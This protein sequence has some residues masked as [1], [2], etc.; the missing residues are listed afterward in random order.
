MPVRSALRLV[1]KARVLPGHND[2]MTR[3]GYV[4]AVRRGAQAPADWI[5]ILHATPGVSVVGQLGNRAQVV[6]SDDAI[7]ITRRQLGEAFI[8]ERFIAHRSD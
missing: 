1:I 6:A 2:H 5:D 8:I 7:E 3:H 4:I